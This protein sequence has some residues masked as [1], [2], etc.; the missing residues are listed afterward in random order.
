MIFNQT[1]PIHPWGELLKDYPKKV[2]VIQDTCLYE[3]ILKQIEENKDVI[4]TMDK[5][6]VIITTEALYSSMWF[7]IARKLK[8][9]GIE[10]KDM[11]FEDKG[12]LINPLS[13]KWVHV[14]TPYTQHY[15]KI[16]SDVR[17]LPKNKIL[18]SLARIPRPFRVVMTNEL[19]DRNYHISDKVLMSCGVSNTFENYFDLASPKNKEIFPISPFGDGEQIDLGIGE[20]PYAPLW[21]SALLNL[22]MESSYNHSKAVVPS[23]SDEAELK[24]LPLGEG[25]DRNF[26]TEK[27]E[28][29]FYYGQIPIFVAPAGYV[30]YIR[31]LG[32]DVFDDFV[33]HNYDDELDPYVRI[34]LIAKE[35]E[36]LFNYLINIDTEDYSSVISNFKDR[37]EKNFLNTQKVFIEA[38]KH[39]KEQV[40]KF[41]QL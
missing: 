3:N 35:I 36:R 20:Q 4:K 34:K 25:W 39:Q 5:V 38:S 32:Y 41:L 18:L 28:K 23:P 27:T 2:F 12:E 10:E 16:P 17:K 21:A 13:R 6:V 22:V 31:K 30:R 19:L 24:F 14:S 37:T 33:N 8:E 7:E 15:Y 40:E 1:D 29:V 26:H 9:C 11:L